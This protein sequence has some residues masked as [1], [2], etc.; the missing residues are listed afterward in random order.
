[1]VDEY[2]TTYTSFSADLS[3]PLVC[4]TPTYSFDAALNLPVDTPYLGSGFKAGFRI[5]IP[6]GISLD[7]LRKYV[8]VSTYKDNELQELNTGN[9][10]SGFDSAGNGIDWFIYFTA[11]KTFNV[12][13]LEVNDGIIP[14]NIPFEF[15]VLYSEGTLESV[16][17]ATIANFTLAA[18]GSEVTLSWQSP[19][20]AAIPYKEVT[21]AVSVICPLPLYPPKETAA[22]PCLTTIQTR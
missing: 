22:P 17:P 6:T 21:M 2:D 16:L 14:L 10:L 12:V 20:L 4:S 1:M 15:D 5:R 13:N 7:T 18:A 3:T 11:S 9:A 19:M 8:A